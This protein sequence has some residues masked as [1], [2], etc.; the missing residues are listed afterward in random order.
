MGTFAYVARDG[1][2]ERISGTV[3]GGS[4]Q[5]VLAELHARHLLPVRVHEVRERTRLRRGVPARRLAVV[6]RQASD[7]LRAGVPLL[8]VLRL[9]GRGRADRRLA[10]VFS[11]VADRVAD[12]GHLADAMATH[13]DVFPPIQIAMIRAG[14][15]GGFLEE[16][17]ERLGVFIEHQADL[18]G[19]VISNLIY[20]IALLAV[21]TGV[22]VF[23]LVFLV[24]KFE[25]FYA[26]I[27]LP[28]PTKILLGASAVL[29]D[30]WLIVLLVPVMLAA[31]LWRMNTHPGWR[32]LRARCVL[33]IP[34][35]GP[36]VRDL[37]V[38]RFARILGTLLRNGIPMLP[39]MEIS[40]DATGHVILAGAIGRATDA[41]RAGETLARPLA[42][43]GLFAEDMVEMISVG[44]S[45]NNLP[46][47]LVTLADTVEKR[48]DRLLGVVV[49]L[50]EPL[51][52][53]AMAGMVLFIFVA[54]VVPM[55][56]MSSSLS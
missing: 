45:A 3:T 36:L 56:R 13:G 27:A 52:L 35:L 33:R 15:R 40:R 20:P 22:V 12:G 10:L 37:A 54:L 53:L 38:G 23:A 24:P 25:T 43:S 21:G 2:G 41:V 46:E 47:V 30:H 18:K 55:L 42:D 16:V 31:L 51:L 32:R 26:R 6:Y 4:E 44:E 1:E 17:L 49:R 9:L 48:V 50:L 34:T 39:A 19:K 14:E 8:R 7:L 29:T 5:A 11:D 28:L